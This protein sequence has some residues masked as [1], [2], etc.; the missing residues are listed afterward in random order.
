MK[1]EKKKIRFLVLCII[2]VI[3]ATSLVIRIF[4]V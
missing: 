4:S 3:T 2:V 1:E